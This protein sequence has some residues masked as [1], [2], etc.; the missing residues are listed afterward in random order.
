M[1]EEELTGKSG[2][3]DLAEDK[4]GMACRGVASGGE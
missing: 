3:L 2:R 1:D 4:D